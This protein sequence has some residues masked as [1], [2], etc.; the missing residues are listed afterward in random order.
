MDTIGL[1]DFD[2]LLEEL[3]TAGTGAQLVLHRNGTLP[4]KGTP[5]QPS[6]QNPPRS[7]PNARNGMNTGLL[8][9]TWDPRSAGNRSLFKELT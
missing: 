7:G 2:D 5:N 9:E 1:D 6:P 3:P 4:T 8:I